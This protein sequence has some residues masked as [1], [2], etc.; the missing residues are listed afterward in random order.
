MNRQGVS[1]VVLT[2]IALVPAL[3][4]GGL[5]QY[6][7]T[8]VP[9]PTTTTTT[10]LPPEP[11]PE[12][13]TQLLSLRRHPTPLADAAAAAAGEA[14]LSRLVSELTTRLGAGA[15]LH[16]VADD[17]TVVAELAPTT[18]VIPASTHKLLVAAVALDVLG[19]DYRFRTELFAAG[20]PVDGVIEGDVYLV[21]GG[22]PLLVTA[23][24]PD[25]QRF[26]A[27]N[28]TPIEP[29]VDALVELGTV[30][31]EG[32][33]VAD[34]SRYDDEFQP[35]SWGAELTNYDGGPVDALLIDDGQI[36]PGNYGLDPNFSAARVFTDLLIERGITVVGQTD[37]R[38]RPADVELVSLGFVESRPL[39][40]VLV[41]LLHTS[42]NNTAEMLLKE[43]GFVA[44]GTG[45]RQDGIDTVWAQ[46]GEWGVPLAGVS[47]A[48][49]SGLS[50]ANQLTCAA[51]TG[52]LTK[53]PTAPAVID[54]LP[55]AGRDGTLADQ[56]LG[57]PAEGVLHAKTGTLT[58]VKGLAG[59]QPDSNR[60]DVTFALVLNG[61]GV[62]DP[63]IHG[64]LWRQLVEL[65]AQLPVVVEPDV[66]PFGPR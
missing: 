28:T 46:L 32:A 18:P 33:L 11:T 14:T 41:E 44:T 34:G 38:P 37:S 48:D 59:V 20:P 3:A 61:D 19:P 47:L 66:T 29:L 24:T 35:P 26:P 40:D 50:R 49:G 45:S 13:A 7:D 9:P 22:D 58:A 21:G 6:A 27:F 2:V 17:G 52:L 51:L 53:A 4:L 42:D 64:P 30:H 55:V 63:S 39:T 54:L 57:T 36:D 43:I 10:T 62:A 12:L 65:V 15:C 5:W 16:I 25:P 56:L 31:I 8:N 1:V 23:D 60:D